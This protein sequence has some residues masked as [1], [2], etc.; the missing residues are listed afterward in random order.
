MVS[1]VHPAESTFLGSG[2]KVNRDTVACIK[3]DSTAQYISNGRVDLSITAFVQ[4]VLFHGTEE[5]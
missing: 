1:E 4:N 3:Q 5:K 2:F